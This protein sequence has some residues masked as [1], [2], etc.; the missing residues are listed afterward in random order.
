MRSREHEAHHGVHDT[1]PGPMIE[2]PPGATF[3]PNPQAPAEEPP[4][5]GKHAP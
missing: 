3:D 1:Q 4:A 5:K 2:L